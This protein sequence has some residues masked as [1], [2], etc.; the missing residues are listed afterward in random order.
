MHAVHA[1]HDHDAWTENNQS[2]AL[3]HR[4][5]QGSAK[6]QTEKNRTEFQRLMQHAVHRRVTVRLLVQALM[7]MHAQAHTAIP[8]SAAPLSSPANDALEEQE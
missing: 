3:T 4:Y 7:G 5:G 6:N 1:M 2:A 8:I